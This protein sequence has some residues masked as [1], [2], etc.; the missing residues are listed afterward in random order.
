MPGIDRRS[1]A[2]S[3]REGV[4]VTVTTS[5]ERVPTPLSVASKYRVTADGVQRVAHPTHGQVCEKPRWC[6]QA[7]TGDTLCAAHV[8]K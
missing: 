1:A 5:C 6:A 4:S 2:S 7:K 3:E 8:A